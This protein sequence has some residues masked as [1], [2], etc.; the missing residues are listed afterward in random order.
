[1]RCALARNLLQHTF[2]HQTSCR[3]GGAHTLNC[4]H[5]ILNFESA[6]YCLHT[7][8]HTSYLREFYFVLDAQH[9]IIFHAQHNIIVVA[10]HN[11]YSFSLHIRILFF[12]HNIILFSMHSINNIIIYLRAHSILARILFCFGCTA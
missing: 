10:H 8:A 4:A 9:N 2:S 12:M 3:G 7:C 5:R 11:A 1:M 6:M